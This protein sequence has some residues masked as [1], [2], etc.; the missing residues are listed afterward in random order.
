VRVAQRSIGHAVSGPLLDRIDALASEWTEMARPIRFRAATP[1]EFDD[2]FGL[3]YEAVIEEGWGRPQDFP[4]GRERDEYDDDA[5]QI[6][7][8][9]GE[10]LAATSRVVLPLDGRPL[11][12][13]AAFDLTV[14]V[15]KGFVDLGRMVVA[16]N[17]R[18]GRHRVFAGLLGQSWLEARAR[19]FVGI[20]GNASA[21][22]IARYE[23]LGIQVTPIGPSRRHWGEERFPIAINIQATAASVSGV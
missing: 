8:A 17:Y 20:V 14:P 4:D 12:T 10:A 3:R 5:I 21:A 18:D 9:D 19:G 2:V 22:V 23:R 13:E 6:V 16:T 11:P 1:R 7:G 15:P